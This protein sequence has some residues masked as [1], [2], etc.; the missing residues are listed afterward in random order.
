MGYVS[1][2]G[3]IDVGN[4]MVFP[5]GTV[6]GLVH[7]LGGWQLALRLKFLPCVVGDEKCPVG[8]AVS[9]SPGGAELR[10]KYDRI[11][12]AVP[13]FFEHHPDPELFLRKCYRASLWSAFSPVED[14]PLR[15]ASPLLGAGA[16]GYPAGDAAKI[17]AS[18]S[19]RWR[20]SAEGEK[21]L[22]FGVPDMET[23]EALVR[24]V[25]LAEEEEI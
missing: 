12:H 2:W 19:V 10:Q 11:V 4:G 15:V 20:E 3:G 17:A 25:E 23:A 22:A 16:R 9:S 14:R 21:V 24:A 6:D 8:H 18:E 5:L 13:P 1:H 7:E